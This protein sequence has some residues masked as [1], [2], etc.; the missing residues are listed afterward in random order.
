V[1]AYIIYII[2]LALQHNGYV[3]LENYIKRDL[4]P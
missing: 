3:P 4:L 2:I 1:C